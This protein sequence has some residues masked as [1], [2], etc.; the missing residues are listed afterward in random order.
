MTA[1]PRIASAKQLVQAYVECGSLKAVSRRHKTSWHVV[2]KFYQHALAEGLMEKLPRG[3]KTK[4]HITALV[5]GKLVV[6][7]PKV[8]GRRRAL[9]AKPLEIAPTGVTRFL[10]TCAQNNTKLHEGFWANL[11]AFKDYYDAELHV[12]RF[13]YIKH[14]LGALGDK[15]TW[16]NAQIGKSQTAANPDK[17]EFWFVP[18]VIPYLS[19]EQRSVAPGLVWRGDANISPTAVNPLSGKAGMTGR[20]SGIFPHTT[21]AMESVPSMEHD[22]VKLLYTTGTVTLRNYIQK[23]AGFKADFHHTYGA[24]LVE[25]WEGNWWCRQINADSEGNFQDLDVVVK[26]GKVT[27]GNPVEAIVWGDVH[28]ANADEDA[29]ALAFKEGGVLDYLHPK[30]QFFHDTLDMYARNHHDIKDPHQLALRYAKRQDNVRK[31]NSQV[32]AFYQY[33]HRSWCKSHAVNS[34]HDRALLLW[35]KNKNAMFDPVNF[36]FWSELNTRV[37]QKIA[38]EKDFPVILREA[39]LEVT[40]MSREPSWL[41]FLAQDE[42]YIVCPDKGGGIECGAHGD[43]GAGGSRGT[44]ASF[45]QIGRRISKGHDHKAAIKQNVHSVGTFRKLRLDKADYAHGPSAW[46]CSH[47]VIYP[48]AKRAII[49]FWR[50]RAWAPR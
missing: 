50:G 34:N 8:E 30:H 18:E 27:T 15:K 47:D 17:D 38:V 43:D 13:S 35:L 10:F 5:K 49:T 3:T 7:K 21:I 32:A 11:L 19:D 4:E 33:S 2:H 20:K 26:N 37:L 29:L 24:L 22:A 16:F 12:S 1:Y 45:T 6:K 23:D 46:S 14:G 44:T 31:E 42:S 39:Y 28:V 41:H 40:G 48:S 36:Q 9:K 25:V